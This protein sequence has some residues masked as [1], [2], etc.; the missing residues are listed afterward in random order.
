MEIS[1]FREPPMS[2]DIP[3]RTIVEYPKYLFSHN[4]CLVTTIVTIS[5]PL[6]HARERSL[7]WTYHLPHWLGPIAKDYR[8]PHP[9]SMVYFGS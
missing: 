2:I 7:T 6:I 3:I 1:F 9:H 8:F 5:N 4:S